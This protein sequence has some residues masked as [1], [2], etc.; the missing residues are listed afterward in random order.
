MRT[1]K[2]TTQSR[3][4]KLLIASFTLLLAQLSMAAEIPRKGIFTVAVF[5]GRVYIGEAFPSGTFGLFHLVGYS[6]DDGECR[7]SYR[8]HSFPR[9]RAKFSCNNG[10]SGKISIRGDEALTG[11]GSG[12]I[13]GQKLS[14]VYGYS[15]S[16]TNRLLDFPGGRKLTVEG[17][18]LVLV[19]P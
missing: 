5:G 13:E 16:K 15:L 14:L 11:K 17:D 7:G 3:I 10:I 1:T 12:I 8:Y 19:E 18:A 9:G 2:N 4:S 6:A